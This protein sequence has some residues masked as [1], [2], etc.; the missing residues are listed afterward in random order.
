MRSIEK[1][2]R[3]SYE[4][5]ASGAGPPWK[6]VTALVRRHWGQRIRHPDPDRAV[7]LCMEMV[8]ATAGE[9][10][11]FRAHAAKALRMNDRVLMTELSHAVLAYLTRWPAD[12]HE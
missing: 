4:E 1:R 6:A 9:L 8:S 2:S 11:L 12:A 3:Q 10:I 7:A 5:R